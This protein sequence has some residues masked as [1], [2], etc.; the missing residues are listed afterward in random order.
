MIGE[1]DKDEN[2]NLVSEQREV[3][4]TTEPLKDNDDATLAK[5]LLN[6][7]R[8]TSK[9]KGKGIMQE[10]ELPKKI[11]KKEIIQLSLDEELAQKL[12]AKELAQKLHA[13]E[14]AKET[15]FDLQQERLKKQKLDEQTEEE[16]KAQADTDQEVEEMKLY[17]KIVPDEDI[18]IDAIP[19]ATKPP[20]IVEY[21]IVKEGMIST[22]YII[23][24]NGSTKR[25]TSMIKLLENIDR[26]DLETL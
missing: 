22:Y 4:E 26:E 21:K 12:H 16:V 13:E 1:I 23:R 24:A 25:S 5:T 2:V 7:K 14:L 19:L 8:S 11:K 9:D 10:T 18:A 20:V 15:G 3:H 17:V 6:I